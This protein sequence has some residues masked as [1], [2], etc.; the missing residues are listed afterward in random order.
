[1]SVYRLETG[2]E[3]WSTEVAALDR[4]IKDDPYI[5]TIALVG[6]YSALA[7]DV[8]ELTAFSWRRSVFAS[9]AARTGL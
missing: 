5:P 8:S 3:E 7:K 6:V 4:P 1:M 9:A 2:F